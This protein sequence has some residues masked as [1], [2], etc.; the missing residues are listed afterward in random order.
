MLRILLFLVVHVAGLLVHRE[1]CVELTQLPVFVLNLQ[2][3]FD[4]LAN[5]SSFLAKEANW[6]FKRSCRVDAPDG[7]RLEHSG[8]MKGLATEAI[9]QRAIDERRDIKA[10]GACMTK[11]ALAL[12]A[13]H[14]RIWE[15]ILQ[16]DFPY[17]I[18]MEDDI[19]QLHPGL[20]ASCVM[21]C[22]ATCLGS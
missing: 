11:G 1:A 14:A 16:Q 12:I 5:L 3:R 18:V 22:M 2:R 17:A 13:G 8:D 10:C 21:Q 19:E 15:H 20:Q 4:R 6:L 7:S 9:V